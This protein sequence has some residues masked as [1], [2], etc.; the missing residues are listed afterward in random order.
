MSSVL[1]E[2]EGCITQMRGRERNEQ[3]VLE[4]GQLCG[5]GTE[6]EAAERCYSE[7]GQE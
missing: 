5:L 6:P 2:A 1:L 4:A 3:K 7:K